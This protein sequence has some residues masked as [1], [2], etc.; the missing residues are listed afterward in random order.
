MIQ[1]LGLKNF[2]RFS[3]NSSRSFLLGVWCLCMLDRTENVA[4]CLGGILEQPDFNHCNYRFGNYFTVS[5]AQVIPFFS[6]FF[7]RAYYWFCSFGCYRWG[8]RGSNSWATYYPLL[9]AVSSS[10]K[11]PKSNPW[12][13]FYFLL[14]INR[15]FFFRS[16]LESAFRSSAFQNFANLVKYLGNFFLRLRFKVFSEVFQK[17]GVNWFG[18]RFRRRLGSRKR[19]SS[20]STKSESIIG[21]DS[22]IKSHDEAFQNSG[23]LLIM[24]HVFES[25][26]HTHFLSKKIHPFLKQNT[27]F[28][29]IHILQM[30]TNV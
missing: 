23:F 1:H 16:L 11:K 10:R 26:L 22:K 21:Q 15:D 13:I 18:I 25:L 5:V 9:S 2:C 4:F 17:F 3:T 14:F 20:I 28:I 27:F 24:K 8:F 12:D 29:K 30:Y 6:E 19:P 7:R